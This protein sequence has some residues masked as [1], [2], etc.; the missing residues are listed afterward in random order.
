MVRYR[1]AAPGRPYQCRLY[2]TESVARL[3]LVRTLREL[4]LG[5]AEVRR[6]VRRETTVAAVA[7][8]HVRALDAQML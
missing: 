7:A 3:Q 5:H 2:G 8:V 1:G 4:G 6:V